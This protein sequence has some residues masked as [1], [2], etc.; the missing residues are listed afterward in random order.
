SGY[1]PKP[2]IKGLWDTI[3]S[4]R[5]WKG[6]IKNRAK[7]GTHYWVDTTI[8]P[9]LGADGKPVQ[10]IAIRADITARKA[11]EEEIRVLNEELE[12]RVALRTHEI[13]AVNQELEAFAYSVSH[14]LRAPLRHIDGFVGLLRR[15]L[16]EEVNEKAKHHL[17]VV[18]GSARQMGT[19]IDDLLGFSRMGRAEIHASLF[20]LGT[21]TRRVIEDLA[22]DAAGRDI[23]WRIGDLPSVQGDQALLRLALSNLIGNALKFTRGKMPARIA[24]S[25]EALDKAVSVT[26][27]DNGAGFDMLYADKLFGVFQRLH[28]QDEF[29]GTGIGLANVA[30]IIHKHGGTVSAQGALNEGAAFT[31]TLPALE[32][33]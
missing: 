13:E 8:V 15:S 33:P 19:L 28:R 1:H 22:P 6:E 16:G 14:D 7:D 11:A 12:A 25:A 4:G 3:T 30:R 27:R 24:I 29:E 5:V 18:S 10:Y 17:D 23:E 31:F 20:N 9:F 2:F 26:V 21:L 32:T